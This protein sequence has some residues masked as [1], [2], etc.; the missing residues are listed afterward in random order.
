MGGQ[1]GLVTCAASG[2]GEA[3]A[4]RLGAQAATVICLDVPSNDCVP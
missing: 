3:A 2:I 4:L 1:V